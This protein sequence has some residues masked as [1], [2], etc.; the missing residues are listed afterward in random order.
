MFDLF[1]I[2]TRKRKTRVSAYRQRSS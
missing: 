1:D 2:K